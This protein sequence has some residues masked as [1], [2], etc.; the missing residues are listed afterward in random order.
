MP[1]RET[2]QLLLYVKRAYEQMME[3]W[4]TEDLKGFNDWLFRLRN[5]VNDLHESL[6]ETESKRFWEGPAPP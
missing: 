5:D 1:Q 2:R 3:A 4:L 6:E